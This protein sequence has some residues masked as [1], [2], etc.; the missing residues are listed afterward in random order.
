MPA[1]KIPPNRRSLTGMVASRKNERLVA[2][3]SSLERDFLVLL[4]F[5]PDVER[6][7]EQPARIGYTD[8]KGVRRTY[9]PD[10]L[11]NYRQDLLPARPPLLCEV[12]YRSELAAKWQEIR[13]KVRAGRAYAR[14]RGWRFKIITDRE[15]R[16]P[17]LQSAKFLRPYR[18]LT[19]KEEKVR[20]IL[21]ALRT[22]GESD[23][24]RLLSLIHDTP[25]KRAELLPT[26]WH[27][28]SH[29]RIRADLNRPLTMCSP[30][31]MPSPV[32]EDGTI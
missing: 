1:R 13:R 24:E 16:T 31:R 12:K 10:V 7:E 15:V 22:V 17:Y 19:V 28:V 9:T 6:Y 3:E 27:L 14:E 4:E 8:E 2:S 26:L 5:D 32:L 23:P 29:G 21:D 18:D 11:V 25:H 20:L 30:L